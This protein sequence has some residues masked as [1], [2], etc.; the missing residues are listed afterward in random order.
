MGK[1]ADFG[2]PIVDYVGELSILQLMGWLPYYRLPNT[3]YIA[4]IVHVFGEVEKGS[5]TAGDGPGKEKKS[6]EKRKKN[7]KKC[8]IRNRPTYRN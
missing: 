8:V 6:Q 7:K 2:A 3:V 1:D 5:W 4:S